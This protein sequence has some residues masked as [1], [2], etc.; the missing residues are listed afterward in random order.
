VVNRHDTSFEDS[1]DYSTNSGVNNWV[2]A[3]C[4]IAF[5]LDVGQQV[6]RNHTHF[7]ATH[8]MALHSTVVGAHSFIGVSR[9]G[10]SLSM[11][12]S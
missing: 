6:R 12:L 2:V 8:R 11:G 3:L 9:R 4:S 1:R 7:S 5:D 10:V